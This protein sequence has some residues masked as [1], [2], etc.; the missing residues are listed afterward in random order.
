MGPINSQDRWSLVGYIVIYYLNLLWLLL[1]GNDFPFACKP[2]ENRI[3][4]A[5]QIMSID[6]LNVHRKYHFVYQP[7]FN[8]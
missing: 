1:N 4:A 3:H 8:S 2:V 5:L 7:H 6:I